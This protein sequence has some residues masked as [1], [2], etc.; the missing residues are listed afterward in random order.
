MKHILKLKYLIPSMVAVAASF[1]WVTPTYANSCEGPLNGEQR[2]LR[3]DN[4]ANLCELT[5]GKVTLVVNTASQCG[6]TGQFEGLEALYQEYK[7][8][9]FTIVGFP[10]NSFRQEHADEEAVAEVC[11]ANFGVTF[12]MMATSD[13]TG[14]RAN[15]VFA[16]LT[17]EKGPPAWNFHKYLVGANGEVLDAFP[18][19]VA[20]NDSRIKTRIESALN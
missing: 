4:V 3:S 11:F 18:S 2:M 13:V 5:K 8:Q 7:D 17:Q 15:P 9:G 19:N 14:R 20:P 10:S 6:F 1:L 16:R 12:P